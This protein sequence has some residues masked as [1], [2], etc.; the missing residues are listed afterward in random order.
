MARRRSTKAVHKPS[1]TEGNT[2][3][4]TITQ[5]RNTMSDVFETLSAEDW[6]ESGAGA[7]AEKG[8][9]GR[10]LKAFV[11]SGEPYARISMTSGRF[12]GRKASTISMALKNARDSKN[13]PEGVGENIRISSKSSREEGGPSFVYLENT[14]AGS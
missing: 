6:Q 11:D 7:V 13:A 5:E 8:E 12:A 9:Y 2:E 1:T 4:T 14:T 10:I 3:V